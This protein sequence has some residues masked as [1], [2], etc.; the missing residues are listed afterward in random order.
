MNTLSM[1][2]EFSTAPV[3]GSRFVQPTT[4]TEFKFFCNSLLRR[5]SGVLR[6]RTPWRGLG[7]LGFTW[8]ALS[9]GLGAAL[10]GF[11][12]GPD[13]LMFTITASGRTNKFLSSPSGRTHTIVMNFSATLHLRRASIYCDTE[14]FFADLGDLDGTLRVWGTATAQ[15][16]GQEVKIQPFDDPAPVPPGRR[17]TS[18]FTPVTA[19][20][21]YFKTLEAVFAPADDV[22]VYAIE[23][24]SSLRVV[25]VWVSLPDPFIYDEQY[26]HYDFPATHKVSGQSSAS[27]C[28]FGKVT[29]QDSGQ[30]VAGAEVV[31]GGV[32]RTT[33]QTGAFHYDAIPPASYTLE[34]SKTGYSTSRIVESIPPFSILQKTYPIIRSPSGTLVVLDA[35]PLYLENLLLPLS[36]PDAGAAAKLSRAAVIRS[37]AAADGITRLL[38]RFEASTPGMVSFSRSS[39]ST[40]DRLTQTDSNPAVAGL[41]TANVGGKHL[42]FALYT[43]PDQI[44]TASASVDFEATFTPQ[45]ASAPSLR[46]T[47]SL[48]LIRPPVV[49]VHGLWTADAAWLTLDH[50]LHDKGFH[51]KRTWYGRGEHAARP[52]ARY[53]GAVVADA[54]KLL[55]KLRRAGIAATQV[56]VVAHSMGGIV[57]R[58]DVSDR[59]L[60]RPDN[61]NAGYFFSLITVDTP[62]WGSRAAS[63]LLDLTHEC[64]GFKLLLDLVNRPV[65]DGA[66]ADLDPRTFAQ[67]I[68]DGIPAAHIRAYAFAGTVTSRADLGAGELK[69]FEHA[70]NCARAVQQHSAARLSE[71]LCGNLPGNNAD[72]MTM[73]NSVFATSV[74]MAHDGIVPLE[75]QLGGSSIFRIQ[76]NVTHT[77]APDQSDTLD[78]IEALLQGPPDSFSPLGFP[79]VT[80]SSL[81]S[82][83]CTTR[84]IGL[85]SV[86]S[87]GKA[88]CPCQTPLLQ[89]AGTVTNLSSTAGQGLKI[90]VR[91]L[92]GVEL[93]SVEFLAKRNGEIFFRGQASQSPY[94]TTIPVPD[95]SLGALEIVA[96]GFDSRGNYDILQ[97]TASVSLPSGVRPLRLV[98][99][100]AA[101]AISNYGESGFASVSAEF[102]DGTVRDIT[103][104]SAGT[105]YA[106]SRPEIASVNDH[107]AWVGFTNGATM[108]TV[109]YG[110]LKLEIPVTVHFSQPEL[111]SMN[112]VSVVPGASKIPVVLIGKNLGGAAR[113]EFLLNGLPDS[114]VQITKLDPGFSGANLTGELT[115][116]STARTGLRTVVVTTP[117]G[118]SSNSDSQG[119]RLFVGPPISIQDFKLV[120][121]GFST[122]AISFRAVGVVGRDCAVQVSPNVMDWTS[123]TTNRLVG[124]EASFQDV[125]PQGASRRFYRVVL[126]PE[127]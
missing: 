121:A 24:V 28:L 7:N 106:S 74:P 120:G 58:L 18:S 42:A 109:T 126:L 44:A 66:V 32:H 20:Y 82:Q 108:I 123:I 45:G 57:S 88:D 65:N 39:G 51:T 52:F 31:F 55:E 61:F 70:L 54:R 83:L 78:R 101:L 64:P 98:T 26:E 9:L 75:S 100:D 50:R 49:M 59:Q 103:V 34:I 35:N 30:A 25:R 91:P 96:V 15:G 68:A 48:R 77:D 3:A 23:Y 124:G 92:P 14:R 69:M 6:W 89:F 60:Q 62:H 84:P 122:N 93:T 119:N 87:A 90:G 8:L 114:A 53:R 36:R 40:G 22:T 37:G 118:V 105:R 11:A 27:S 104:P 21:L 13:P 110:T 1:P 29:D 76:T 97:T 56:S 94:E 102:S 113:V 85:A 81:Q 99:E 19:D 63:V 17:I 79:Q 73:A 67:S 72:E 4:R 107:G 125:I 111:F 46:K 43:V 115:V 112:P 12:A 41:P 95:D 47:A 127:N 116:A 5:F 86:A 117:G 38:L 33:D 16:G 2:E 71:I 80:S 10:Q